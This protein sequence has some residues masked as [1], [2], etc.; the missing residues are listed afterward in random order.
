M[1]IRFIDLTGKRFGRLLIVRRVEN[2]A[3]KVNSG[4]IRNRIVWE[5]L[6]DCGKITLC[7]SDNL[8]NGA[9][10]SCGC[11]KREMRRL[12]EGEASFN[13]LFSVYR[14][15]SIFRN[16]DFKLSKEDFIKITQE[17]CFYCGKQPSQSYKS[18][19]STGDYIYNGIDRI[20]SSKGYIDGN[21]VPCCGRCNEAKMSETQ[22]N[23]ISWIERV[24]NN[25]VKRKLLL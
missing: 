16:L 5:C 6:C 19:C 22:E 2:R 8:R 1:V 10:K 12:G 9:T 17:N 24:Y 7:T 20:D 18:N 15:Q 14:K 3:D 25:L 21:I 4:R 23:F 13:K 11:L